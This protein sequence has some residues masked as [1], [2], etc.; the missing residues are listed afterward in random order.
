MDIK[1]ELSNPFSAKGNWYKGNLHTHTTDSDG[2]LSPREVLSLYRQKGYD[3]LSLTDHN[4]LTYSEELKKKGICLIP[5]EEIDGGKSAVGT[6][7][8]I[9]ALNIKKEIVFTNKEEIT[10]QEIINRIRKEK[11]E[12]IIAHPYWSGLTFL[13]ILPLEGYLGIEV[14]NSDCLYAVGRGESSIHWDNLLVKDKQIFG[15]AVDDA[16][17]YSDQKY[18]P[19]DM[20]KSWIMVKANL[21]NREAIMNSI[22]KGLFYSSC[23][24]SIKSLSVEN[25][26]VKVETSPVSSITFV[27]SPAK[28]KRLTASATMNQ[29]EY[30]IKGN[31]KYIRIECVD[32]LGRKAW[33]NPLFFRNEDVD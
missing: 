6:S 11:G 15:F 3:F 9:I 22:K 13:D 27:A 33:T 4:K 21:L 25:G 30:E 5:G 1:I 16:H 26:V 20:G 31:E 7:F 18:R 19:M 14:F 29:A 8:H 17:H 2:E 12:A 24:P 23:G 32:T 28:G 10:V